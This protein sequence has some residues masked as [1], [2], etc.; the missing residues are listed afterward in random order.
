MS[1]LGTILERSKI[2]N[3]EVF[4]VSLMPAGLLNTLN[5]DEILDLFAYL[6]SH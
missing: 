3:S 4:P 6:M 1:I 5:K 2:S